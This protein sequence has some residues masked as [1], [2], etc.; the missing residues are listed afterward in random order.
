MVASRLKRGLICPP[1]VTANNVS[2]S[3]EE[4]K[5]KI[6]YLTEGDGDNNGTSINFYEE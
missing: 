6:W 5:W 4:I 3:M 1:H 2:C